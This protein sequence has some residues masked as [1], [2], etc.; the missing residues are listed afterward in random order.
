[1]VDKLRL[2]F[3]LGSP[4][5]TDKEKG[6]YFRVEGD[7]PN[8]STMK[9]AVSYISPQIPSS[10]TLAH[11][12]FDLRPSDLFF[13]IYCLLVIFLKFYYYS[14]TFYLDIAFLIYFLFNSI[15]S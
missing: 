5:L 10:S 4:G 13:L 14:Y 9:A 15:S 1:M 12:G 11:L 7:D 3:S 6:G 8:E 2:Q